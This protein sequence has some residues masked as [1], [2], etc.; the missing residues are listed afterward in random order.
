M[1]KSLNEGAV[2]GPFFNDWDVQAYSLSGFF[3][4]DK[5]LSKFTKDEMEL[6][7]HGKDKK[8]RAKF[9]GKT[10]NLTCAG[11]IAKIE[12]SYVQRD[13]KTLSERTQQA[14]M[15]YRKPRECPSRPPRS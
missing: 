12:R 14:V 7:L 5:K 11:I 3:D 10:I 2:L 15:P 8:F 6:L 13:I 4:N 1:S 9:G